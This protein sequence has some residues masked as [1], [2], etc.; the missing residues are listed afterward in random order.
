MRPELTPV[1]SN[2]DYS[3]FKA[4]LDQISQSLRSGLVEDLAIDFALEGL[5]KD[6]TL[7]SK[8][9]QAVFAVFALRAEVLRHL[10]GLPSFRSFSRLLAGSNLLADFCGVLTLEGIERTSK[11]TL[12]RASKFF[13]AEHIESLNR[14]LAEIAGNQDWSERLEL[15]EAVD[16]T[17]CLM[18]STCLEANIHFPV[19]WMLLKD[20]SLTLLQAIQL[21]REEGLL[22]RMPGSAGDL[23]TAMNRLCIEMTHSRRRQDGKKARKKVLRAMKTLLKRIGKHAER[24]RDKLECDY[25]QTKWS[26]KQ[27]RQIID[28]INDK[29]DLLP[30]VIEQAHEPKFVS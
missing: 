28:R 13:T 19:D 7:K 20:V 11:S 9:K 15:E 21:I 26:D 24:H 8:E 30:Q 29:L 5:P 14:H 2:V 22:C 10:L 16:A 12:D 4:E 25:T 23:I 1:K 17:V 3:R 18:D 27:A 6:A